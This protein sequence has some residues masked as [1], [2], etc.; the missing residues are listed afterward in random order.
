MSNLTLN[1]YRDRFEI[2]CV[3][4]PSTTKRTWTPAENYQAERKEV[5]NNDSN[6]CFESYDPNDVEQMFEMQSKLLNLA[7][8]RGT[9][10]SF[11]IYVVVDDFGDDP[12]YTCPSKSPCALHARGRH[13]I[14]SAIVSTQK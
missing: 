12:I 10:N 14:V 6:R 9:R 4:P 7:K 11:S 13:N 8:A 2:T 3:F 5:M 1:I